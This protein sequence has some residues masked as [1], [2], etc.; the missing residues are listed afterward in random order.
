MIFEYYLYYINTYDYSYKFIVNSGKDRFEYDIDLI[1]NFPNYVFVEN[2]YFNTRWYY[3]VTKSKTKIIG[4]IKKFNI[5]LYKHNSYPTYLIKNKTEYKIAKQHQIDKYSYVLNK[6]NDNGK[7][8]KTI[9]NLL[10]NH[11]K[12]KYIKENTPIIKETIV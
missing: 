12:N 10:I 7:L 6:K 5:G 4:N 3:S 9:Y 2:N 11:Y 1:N 8:Y